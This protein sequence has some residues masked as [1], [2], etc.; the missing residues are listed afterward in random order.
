VD[1]AEPPH[2]RGVLRGAKGGNGVAVGAGVAVAAG[3][4]V[5]T[6]AFAPAKKAT[7]P[8]RMHTLRKTSPNR[9]RVLAAGGGSCMD[10]F[11][12]GEVSTK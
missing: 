4:G 3:I 8:T 2:G 5:A 12:I 11:F 9:I 6:C 1:A 7:K 10:L